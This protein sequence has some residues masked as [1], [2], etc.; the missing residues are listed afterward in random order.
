MKIFKLNHPALQPGWEKLC[1]NKQ[2]QLML[3]WEMSKNKKKST[4][5]FFS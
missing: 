5:P 3:E 1:R 2:I 4:S